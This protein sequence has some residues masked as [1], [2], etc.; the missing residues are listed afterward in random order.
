MRLF[1]FKIRTRFINFAA[2]NPL[3]LSTV[4]IPKSQ[5]IFSAHMHSLRASV[6]KL[7]FLPLSQEGIRFC[8]VKHKYLPHIN[9]NET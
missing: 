4:L 8:N 3:L 2:Q 9:A 6:V 1:C 5:V 7:D